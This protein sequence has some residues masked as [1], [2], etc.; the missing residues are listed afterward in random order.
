MNIDYIAS[1]FKSAW[2]ANSGLVQ[3]RRIYYD[4]AQQA[5][6]ITDFPY[7]TFTISAEPPD[8]VTQISGVQTRICTYRLAVTFWTIQG[9]PSTSGDQITD[10]GQLMRAL[11]TCLAIV[12]SSNPWYNV[13]G[14]LGCWQQDS[15]LVKDNELY[16]GKDVL[17]GTVEFVIK[18][19][20]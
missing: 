4:R 13:P 10:H 7:I 17:C 1:S 18:T 19:Q 9:M 14:F 3:G 11:E 16:L 12:P 6:S 2:A 20:E 5:A 8:V 15:T